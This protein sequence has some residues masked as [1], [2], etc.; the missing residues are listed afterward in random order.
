MMNKLD[1]WDAP[2]RDDDMKFER[3]DISDKMRPAALFAVA[4]EAVVENRLAGRRDL[5]NAKVRCM[6]DD[7]I[8]DREARGA[9]KLSGGGSQ[10]PPEVDQLKLGEMTSDFAEEGSGRRHQLRPKA[11]RVFERNCRNAQLCFEG[12][13]QRKR[14]KRSVGRAHRSDGMWRAT[15]GRGR[16]F[17]KQEG[18]LKNPRREARAKASPPTCAEGLGTPPGCSQVKDGLTTRRRTCQKE[19]TPMKTAAGPR[20]TTRH[21]N[22][23]TLAAVLLFDELSTR[24]A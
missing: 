19:R 11:R 18:A 15:T 13:E 4:P 16:S 24:I 5:D 2:I 21:S 1:R 22:L 7:M 14:P 3:G 10:P 20:R 6:M 8:R 17:G 23:G 12:S 9:I